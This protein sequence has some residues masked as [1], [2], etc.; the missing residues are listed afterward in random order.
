MWC[1]SRCCCFEVLSLLQNET[2]LTPPPPFFKRT[3]QICWKYLI[4]A[5]NP[6][7]FT[8]IAKFLSEKV[9]KSNPA[10]FVT[11]L[12]TAHHGMMTRDASQTGGYSVARETGWNCTMGLHGQG[13]RYHFFCELLQGYTGARVKIRPLK[14]SN[15][16]FSLSRHRK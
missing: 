14:Q 16:W 8:N 15:C 9:K 7:K 12:P 10:T 13:A 11:A 5:E 6:V 1:T 2:F 3:C 4:H